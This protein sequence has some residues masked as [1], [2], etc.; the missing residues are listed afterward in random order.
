MNQPQT[1]LPL[2]VLAGAVAALWLGAL[3]IDA[4][5]RLMANFFVRMNA[6]LPGATV[7]TV[8]AV[9]S[10]AHWLGAAFGTLLLGALFR[11]RPAAFA[12]ASA[13]ALAVALLAAVLAAY[14]L[15]W[16]TGLCGEMRPAW[17]W[18]RGTPGQGP[19]QGCV[20]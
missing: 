8:K 20:R 10:H 19:G 16:P 11:S 3:G 9:Q 7:F 1:R 12:P 18:E 4:A 2:L 6:D 15:A 17:S 5:T 14:T 13:L